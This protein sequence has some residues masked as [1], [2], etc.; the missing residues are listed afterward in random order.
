MTPACNARAS[1]KRNEY[2]LFLII[3]RVLDS[4]MLIIRKHVS[5]QLMVFLISLIMDA[6]ELLITLLTSINDDIVAARGGVTA[7]ADGR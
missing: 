4:P 3:S 5:F 7:T 1:T 6:R 2:R